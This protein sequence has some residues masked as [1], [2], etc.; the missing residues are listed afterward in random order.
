[1]AGSTKLLAVVIPMLSLLTGCPT[2]P[3]CVPAET[4]CVEGTAEICGSDGAWR[5]LMDCVE[6]G[7]VCCWYPGD[8][9][10]GL[11]AGH[12]CLQECLGDDGE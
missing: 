12:T 1:M 4:R 9:D 7:M 8:S 3:A 10:A 11:P 6:E 2:S 5:V